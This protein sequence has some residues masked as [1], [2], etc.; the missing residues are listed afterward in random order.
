MQL[1]SSKAALVL[2]A[3]TIIVSGCADNSDQG[4]SVSQTDGVEIES[5]TATPSEIF[6]G[7]QATFEL[8]LRNVGGTR[9]DNVVA[10]LYN[11]PFE[12]DRSWNIRNGDEKIS[13]NSLR[14]PD[15]ETDAPST[16]VP[17]TWTIEAPDL[18]Q[19]VTI[20]YDFYTRVLYQYDTTAT[21]EV[22][23][24]SD[25]RFRDQGATRSKPTVDN[26]GGPIQME[27]KTRTPIVFFEGSSEQ[28][29]DICVVVKNEGDGRPFLQDAY[30]SDSDNYAINDDKRDKVEVSLQHSGSRVSFEDID[31]TVSMVGGR[32]VTCFTMGVERVSSQ[33]I[34]E[35]IPITLTAEYGYYQESSTSVTVK[36][37]SGPG[38]DSSSNSDSSGDWSWS[39]SAPDFVTED[40]N[41]SDYCPDAS[42]ENQEEYCEDES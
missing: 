8:Q 23:A 14:A 15:P 6:E 28:R 25:Q 18:S 35:T 36:G 33:E 19:G 1:P 37:R 31:K 34:Q 39:S 29:S 9:A 26:S 32:G 7:Q 17:R 21:T 3:L 42:E 41:P 38:S 2:L 20:P 40:A 30:D 27:V 10:K 4:V 11:V 12:G 22:T 16:S 13:F 24:M 5:F